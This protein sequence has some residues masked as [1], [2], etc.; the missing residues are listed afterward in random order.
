MIQLVTLTLATLL[1]A[2]YTAYVL[3]RQRRSL[4]NFA[5]AAGLLCFSLLEVFDFLALKNPDSYLTWKKLSLICESLLPLF[6]FTFCATFAGNHRSAGIPRPTR[7]FL[8]LTP[9]FLLFALFVDLDRFY[10][11]PDFA[12]EHLLFLGQA[13]YVFYLGL[14]LSL[15]FCLVQLEWTFTG[16]G[17][18]DRWR[19]K[20]ELLGVGTLL[21]ISVF[22]YSQGLLYRSLDMSLLPARS[23]AMVIGVSLMFFSR[24]RRGMPSGLQV[25]KT[26]AYRSIVIVAVGLYLIGL[27]LAGEGM[28]YLGV[29]SQ[30]TIFAVIAL[31]G[32][33][34]LCVVFLS[35]RLRRKARVFLHKNFYKAK[36]DY[37][38]HWLD[39]TK[40]LTSAR[41][42]QALHLAILASFCGAFSIRG[43]ALFLKD[44][45]GGDFRCAAAH[46]LSPPGEVRK[47]NPLVAYLEKHRW[48]YCREEDPALLSD[49]STGMSLGG[50]HFGV[51]LFFEETLEGFILLGP[52]MD[53]G[54]MFIYEDFDLMKVMARQ[55]TSALLNL[56]FA[57]QLSTAREMAAIGKVSAFVM[58][59]LK[60]SVSNL[61]LVVE[62]ARNN[63]DDPDFQRE[64]LETLDNTVT[65]M[66][67]LIARLRNLEE[68]AEL[69][70]EECDL[71][72][73][74]AE[75]AEGLPKKSIT[76]TGGPVLCAVDR[77]EIGKVVLNLALNAL[78]ATAGEGPVHLDVGTDGMAFIRCR[79]Q[80][81]GMAEKFLR[82]RLFK[83]FE[84][85]KPKGFGIGLYQC[86]QIVEAHGGRIEVR[87]APEQGS[88]FTV[89]LPLDL[90][91]T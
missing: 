56:K 90:P 9:A 76:L 66:K 36:Y 74:V 89:Y 14:L 60:N 46:E 53:P 37:R 47:G 67:G 11:S 62:N 28:R 75:S 83:P 44:A 21:T 57:E 41:D 3:L 82:E 51:P 17:R 32:G 26:L 19:V 77:V 91:S 45:E 58:H 18:S 63:M 30:R 81:C 50:I 25:S 42:E 6:W 31:L 79:D 22:Y 1:A 80:G 71:A 40:G 86:R 43:A 73:L 7:I 49:N 8:I 16:L 48:V 52:P 4:N 35:E 78:D 61:A 27:G 68:K 85:T 72:A 70:L 87:S 55:A 39:F 2:A 59:D 64:M 33:I 23:L 84:T 5:V 10:I 54:E 13:G 34:A 38:K 69:K 20:F 12:E 24:I 15:T 29:S 65:K 88:E